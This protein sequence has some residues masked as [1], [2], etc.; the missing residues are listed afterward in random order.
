[1]TMTYLIFPKDNKSRLYRTIMVISDSDETTKCSTIM[2]I[3]GSDEMANPTSFLNNP[4][5]KANKN[6][7]KFFGTLL[8][9]PV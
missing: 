2:D 1:M 4:H 6:V 5:V 7:V 8:N 3:W 9:L